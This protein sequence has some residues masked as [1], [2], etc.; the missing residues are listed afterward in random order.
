MV[1]T[2]VASGH[3]YLRNAVELERTSV[4]AGRP[5]GGCRG[6]IVA[7]CTQGLPCLCSQQGIQCSK[8]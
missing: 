1:P 2:S 6:A 3:D 4:I 7:H 8:P 5:K